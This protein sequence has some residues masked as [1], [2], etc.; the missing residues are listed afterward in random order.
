MAEIDSMPHGSASRVP[1]VDT[2]H[3]LW[4]L[5]R[6]PYDWLAAEGRADI[7]ALLGEYQ[8]IRRNYGIEELLGD[9]A[10][11]GIVKS[12]H[13][14]ADISEP[15]PVVETAWLQSIADVYGFPHGIVAYSDLR[16]PGVEA[17]LDRHGSHANLRGFRM[18][19]VEGLLTDP[20]FRRGAAALAGRGLSLQVDVSPESMSEL[21]E[22]ARSQP[23]LQV[24]LGHTGLPERR[25]PAYFA[26]WRLALKATAQIPNVA[27]KISGLGM[28]DHRWTTDSIRPWVLEAVEAFGTDRCVFGTNWPVDRLY[29]DLP[30]L[31]D[32][33]RVVV[34]NFSSVEQE[35]LLFRNAERLY[36]I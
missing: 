10:A 33:Y 6:Y 14:Q 8:A 3:H 24:F 31:T 32:A 9:F 27:L 23:D 28:G 7:T 18:S 1:I 19:D 4:D 15:D 22:L 16:M 25:D 2:H 11:V 34:S 12:V 35:S 5:R 21:S 13:V 36:A 30:T 26:Q 29:S 17:E 20:S